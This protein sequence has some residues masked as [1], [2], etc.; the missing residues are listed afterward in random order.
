MRN[1]LGIWS[2]PP[3]LLILISLQLSLYTLLFFLVLI[4]VFSSTF[5]Q[6]HLAIP[7]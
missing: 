7:I 5:L 6:L 4:S 3:Y 1:F 2:T